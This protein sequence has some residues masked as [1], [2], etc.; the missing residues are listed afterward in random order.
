MPML[1]RHGITR[2]IPAMNDQQKVEIMESISKQLR[3]AEAKCPCSTL[4]GLAEAVGADLMEAFEGPEDSMQ[5]T[6][7]KILESLKK[8][9]DD[10][11]QITGLAMVEAFTD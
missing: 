2:V 10:M 6:T 7:N 11:P 1:G 4:V 5:E 8:A 3:L 9:V